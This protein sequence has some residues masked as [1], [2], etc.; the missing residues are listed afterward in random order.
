MFNLRIYP[1][2]HIMRKNLLWV[3]RNDSSINNISLLQKG[4]PL[5]LNYIQLQAGRIVGRCDA[6]PYVLRK[7]TVFSEEVCCLVERHSSLVTPAGEKRRM[8]T[9]ILLMRLVLLSRFSMFVVTSGRGEEGGMGKEWKLT[10]D[11]FFG[12]MRLFMI[13]G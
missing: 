7:R 5:R 6:A 12:E 3:K 13:Q 2:R 4:S 10:I 1:S 9:L 11:S 8:L